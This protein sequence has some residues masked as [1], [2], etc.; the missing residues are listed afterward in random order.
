MCGNGEEVFWSGD[1]LHVGDTLCW[2]ESDGRWSVDVVDWIDNVEVI[3]VSVVMECVC[4]SDWLSWSDGEEEGSVDGDGL[5]QDCGVR[6]GEVVEIWSGIPGVVE[7]VS[8]EVEKWTWEHEVLVHE[9]ELKAV[10]WRRRW[11]W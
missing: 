3:C 7:N 2:E 10:G 6:H 8:V 9:E 1:D 4:V 11:Q 5:D